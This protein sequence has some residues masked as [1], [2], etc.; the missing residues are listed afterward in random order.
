MT[1]AWIAPEQKSFFGGMSMLNCL[2]VGVG[3]FVGAVLRYLVSMIP[4]DKTGSFPVN[5]LLINVRQRGKKSAQCEKSAHWA[6]FFDCNAGRYRGRSV[7]FMLPCLFPNGN[8]S[9]LATP[10]SANADSSPKRGA[11]GA[12]HHKH[13]RRGRPLCRP[14]SLSK[15]MCSRAQIRE[16]RG[17]LRGQGPPQIQ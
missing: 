11:K 6:D 13:N 4:L 1:S 14:R 9:R 3:G 10:Q 2:A 7:L 8:V 12:L 5:T 15:N 17:S 16:P